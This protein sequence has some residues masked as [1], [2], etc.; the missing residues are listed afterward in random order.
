MFVLWGFGER[1]LDRDVLYGMW[2]LHDFLER[3]GS[4]RQTCQEGTPTQIP[5]PT[6]SR[7]ALP[8]ASARSLAAYRPQ[9]ACPEEEEILR[10]FGRMVGAEGE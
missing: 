7:P 6:R 10:R 8:L 9:T 5:A 1:H 2:L 3:A 4:E